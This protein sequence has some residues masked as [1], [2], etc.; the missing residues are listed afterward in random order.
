[1]KRLT[2]AFLAIGIT[3]LA[4]CGGSSTSATSGGGGAPPGPSGSGDAR[5]PGGNGSNADKIVG[6]WKLLKFE[7][8]NPPMEGQVTFEFLKDGTAKMGGGDKVLEEGK[9]KIDGDT[10]TFTKMKDPKDKSGH[11]TIKTLTADS[12]VLIMEFE[13][14]KGKGSEMEFKKQ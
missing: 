3:A 9:Y 5:R 2:F 14:A 12:L 13:E 10:I 4:G 1:M 11:A 8:K 7:G 6:K